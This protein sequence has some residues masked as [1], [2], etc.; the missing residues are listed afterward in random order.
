M[1]VPY[2][3]Y[4]SCLVVSAVAGTLLPQVAYAAPASSSNDDGKGIVDTVKGWFSDDD[5]EAD[6]PPVGGKLEIPSREKLPKGKKLPKAKRVKE[7]TERRTS[8]ARFF[9]LSDGRVEA[10]LSAVPVSYKAGKSWKPIDTAVR[11]TED[12]GFDFANTANTGRSW[13]GSDP[14]KL[15]RFESAGGGAISMGLT[16]AAA[17]TLKPQ[18]DGDTVTYKDA[19]SGADLQYKVGRGQVKENIVLAERPAGPVSFTFTLNTEGLT[20]KARK[21]GSVAFYGEAPGTPVMVIPAPYMTDAKKAPLSPTGGTYSTKVSQKLTRDGK[22]W[23][24]TVAPDAKWL[25]AKERQYPVVIDPTITVAPNAATSQDTM[26]LSDQPSV[27]FNSTWKMSAG[28]T[29]TGIA[30]SLI[31]FPLTEIP[32]GVKVDA[33][34]L[35]MY[36]DQAH[37]TNSNAVTI[38]AHRAT[39]A[40]DESTA[41]WSNTSALVG[42]LSAT[43]VMIDDG[44]V[45]T[46]AVGEWPGGTTTGGAATYDDFAYNK[47]ALTGETYSWQPQVAETDSYRVDVHYPAASDAATAAPYTVNYNGGTKNYTVNQTGTGGVWKTLD[48]AEYS[49]VKGNTGKVVLG[50][51]GSST[52]R[53]LADSVRLVNPAQIVKP[54]GKYNLWHDF[55]VTDTVQRWVS[56]VNPNY[57]FVL[58]AKDD[59]LAGTL[60]G[61]PRYE[62]GDGDYGGETSTIPRLT[63]TYGKVGTALNSPTVVHGTGPELSW[64]AY[65]NAGGAANDE[66]VE[67]QLH[68]ST[69]QVFTPSAA[70]L[71]APIA[72][73]A[74]TYTDTTAVPTPDSSSS[75]IGKSY[76]Y[77]L[78]VKT[79][80]GEL[81]GS[82]TRVVGI[83]K[84]G[85]TMKIIQ[86]GQT[87]T[88]L[89]SLQ[90]TTNQDAI[91]SLGVGQTWLSVGNNSPTYGKTRAVVKFPTSSIPTT[92]TV[93]ENKMYMWGAETTSTTNGAIYE[94]H[95]LTRDFTEN[96]ATWNNATLTTPWTTAGGDMS[97][98]V[99]DT[100][101]QITDEVG[102]HW[103]DATGLM[104]S[105]V[106]TPA[107]NKGVAV[108]LKD[109]TTTGPQER[110]LFLSSEASD[111]QLRPYMQ[112]IYVDSTTE[113][114][115]YAPT[116]PA[117]MTPNSQYTVEFTVTNTTATAWAAGERVLS[118]TWKIPDGTD[119]TTGGN[120]LS[121]AIPALLP[122]KSA[123][124][125][126]QVKTPINSDEGNKRLDYV[127]GWDVKKVADGTWLSA[128]TGAIPPL[129]QNVTV[130]DPTSNTLG[131]EKFYDYAGKNTGAGSTVM[132]NLASGNSVWSYNAINNPGRGL[133]TFARVAYNSLDTS[134]TVL[135][136]GWSAQISG[137]TRLG[138]PLEFHPKPS[139]TEIRLPDGD[140]TTHVFRWDATNSV[141]KAPAGVHY[142]LTM[143]AGLD[144]KPTKDPVPDAW[145]LTRPDGTRFLFGCDGYM[146][147]AVDN[148]GNTQ[149]YTYEERK[150]NN[151]PT[152]F[153][154]YITDP[155][156]R[157]S[158]TIDYYGKGDATY[159]YINDSG[160]KVSGTNLTNSKIYDHVKSI[161]DIST[162]KIS[163]YYTD[164]GLLGQIGDG[165]TSSQPKVFKF[166]YDA[167]Q[168]NKN[169]KLVKATD[170]RGNNTQ[171]AYYAPQTGDD[172]KYHWWTKTIT[173]RLAFTTGFAYKANTANTNFTDT[174]VTDAESHAT[175]HVTDDFF[176]PV[177][178]TDAKSQTTKMSWDADNNVTYM[179]AANGAKAAS[180]YDSKTG[181][182]LRQWDP[183]TTKSWSSF[184]QTDYCDPAKYPSG[185]TKFEYQTRLDGYS[186]DLFRKTSPLGNVWEFGYDAFGNQTSVTDP[187]GVASATAGDYQST[188]TYDAYGQPLTDT[189]ANGH[190][191]TYADYGP[192]GYPAT[193]K[194]A[195]NNPTT[196]VYDDRGN[197]KEVVN[198]KGAKVTQNYDYFGRPLDQKQP[199]DQ[200]AGVYITTPAPVY[201]ANNNTLKAFGPNGAETS[202]VYDAADQVTDSLAPK[203]E[204]TD[205]ERRTTTTYD[206]VGNVKTV[207]E[208]KGNLTPTVGDYTTTYTLDEVYRPVSVV[209]AKGDKVSSTYDSVGNLITVVDPKKNATPDSS[210]FTSKYDYDLDNRVV[211]TTDAA[212]K[213]TTVHY[214]LDGRTDKATDAE[215]NT[216]ETSFDRRGLTK[217][218]KVP[219][220]KDGSGVITYRATKFEYDEVGNKTKT[221][222]PRGVE[223]TSDA[224]DFT[225]ET[226]Y[227]ELNRVKETL[228]PFKQGDANYGSPDRTHYFYDTVGQL[229]KVSAPP[230]QG[231]TVRN[232]T[233]YEYYDNGWTKSAKDA[234]DITTA[235][236]YNTLGQ[237]TKNTLTSAGGSSQRTMTWDFYP[238]GNQKARSDDGVPVGKQVV[239]VDS[240]DIH[241]TATQGNWDASQALGQWGYDVRT[242]AKG[243][244][245]ESF[246]WQLNIPQDGTYEVFA[247]HG[248]VTGAATDAPF[249]IT[250][251]TGETTRTVNQS[252]GSGTWVSLGSYSFTESGSQKVTLTDAANGT[253]VADGIKL[254]R[255]NTGETDNEKKD[256][257]YKYDANGLL[258]EVKD[259]SPGAKADAYAMAYDELNQ[260]SK[261][262]EKLGSTVKNTTS[263]TYD[264]NGN[265]LETTHDVTWSKAEYDVR[266]M[267]NKITNADTPT[268]G[269]QQITTLSYTDRGQ[270]L[271]Q[272]KP[273]GNTVDYAYWL[274]GA[275]KSQVEKKSSGTVVASH[276]LEY[277]PNGNRSKDTAKLMNAD[278]T[279]AYLDTVSTFDYDPQDRISKVTKTGSGAGTEE[280]VYDGNSNI[281]EQKSGGITSTSTYDRNR[282]LKT[283][284]GGVASTYNYDPLGRLDTVSS[285]GSVQEKYSYDGFDRIAKH[286]A[287]TG[288]SAKTTSYVYDA[289]DRTASET[290]SGT[291]GKTTA[292]T[293]LGM[294]SKVL[295]EEVAGKA[296]KSY[297][298]SPWGQKLTQIKHKDTGPHEYSQF[299][300]HPKGDVEAITKEDGNTRATYGYTAY[301]S[302]DDAQFTGADKP[303]AANPDKEQYNDY[304]YNAHR[305]DDGSGTYDMGFRNYSP[306]LN[307]FLTRDMY[308]GALDDMS[309]ATDPYTG[310]RY[311]FAGGNP[312]SFVELDGHLFGMDISLSDVGHAALDVAGMVPVIGEAADVANGIWYAAEG[313]YADA[314]MSF[315]SAVPGVGNAVTAAKWAKK[316]AKAVDAVKSAAKSGGKKVAGKAK[317]G[318]KKAKQTVSKGTGKHRAPKGK[319]GGVC[320]KKNS[321]V[322]GT[323]VAMADGSTKNI[324]DLK[325]G[326]YVLASDPETGELQARQI[327]DTRNHSGVKHLIT[328]TVDPDGKDGDAKPATITATDE[329]PFWLPDFGKWVNA[330]DLEPGMWLQTSAGTWVQVTAVDESHRT[331]RVF[332]LTVDG[333]HTYY[334]QAG[335][336]PVLVHNCGNEEEAQHAYIAADVL[337]QARY[338]ATNESIPGV[339][340]AQG[341]YGT[342]AV[343]GVRN[344]TTGDISIRTA[345]NH[346]GDAPNS[347]PQWAQNAFVQ[348][349][350]HAETTILSSLADNEEVLFG[351]ASRNV[352]W[353]CH[354]S[355][356][357]DPGIV[358]GGPRFRGGPL[359]SPFRMFWRQ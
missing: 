104:Q 338:R 319:K 46:A 191:T 231:Q 234:F 2:R 332:N 203:D 206:K 348:G 139:P 184:N 306:G 188:T 103:W 57:G 198:A 48:A 92:A 297:Q 301:G 69:Q 119:V 86:A 264:V 308:G 162:R 170:P 347:W 214:D 64:P 24:L 274:N 3:R 102:R 336:T 291:N 121:T 229:S 230:S 25:A 324:E 215:G 254:V 90:P 77:Q 265:P 248:D 81:L 356:S 63:V 262:E 44:A 115:Y 149:T 5:E 302:D 351:A 61:G 87:D 147:S 126:A 193:I 307:R 273:N 310:N 67:Y 269:N 16:G 78:A 345:V 323:K 53:T 98:T 242:N 19:A 352:C 88:T 321:F 252:T 259:L 125:Q 359:A 238:S 118:Y 339:R 343:V 342:T 200:A 136:H 151:K 35:G 315:A 305:Y 41:T 284:A 328:L 218:V 107:N 217:E 251:S 96:Q 66:I 75:E 244:G 233:D 128:G 80:G 197:T 131:L 327:T 211:K 29:D 127:L 141:W 281:V 6:K 298:Y 247:R 177:Q 196:F 290:T 144:C 346:G 106:K 42:E 79:K 187:E 207:T 124:I 105:W 313:N 110:T 236:D 108:K 71:I 62:A 116:T 20:P 166:T 320:K 295:R 145:T 74:T 304:R 43:T 10:E 226:V 340:G 287:G 21:D 258:S 158:L 12:K 142:K 171:F 176:R 222:S 354:G 111:P 179:E 163:F 263:L 250:H 286:T 95:S 50:D 169:V 33:A 94:L 183:E 34:R 225:S 224:T 134:D 172:P 178:I 279:A 271:K 72:S 266:D 220:S 223:T 272:T 210:D 68:R 15:L 331:Q 97:A 11:A 237:Q 253:V 294:E 350:G 337:Q 154:K 73:T 7:L 40:W 205:S 135:G 37:T 278:N 246:T 289:F 316:G 47:N 28:K 173:D 70:T 257:T 52:T 330:E 341:Q 4:I 309:L 152:K 260:L 299:L 228:S 140:G 39:G 241:N 326:E 76:F 51:T 101:P 199:K 168:G 300:Y 160:A 227:D 56:G 268:A 14:D 195:L 204:A 349:E 109:E 146:T 277:D 208:P 353:G 84:A 60:T 267:I 282:L 322:P 157:Q 275:V 120:Q 239:V 255:A 49:F 55:P 194:D 181:Y 288:A 186:A 89:S 22:N 156:G 213:F 216:S 26:V 325:E 93:L 30:R 1:K 243:T 285:N 45:G 355:L 83:P 292:F 36:Y 318:A 99:A 344:T 112:V 167:T 189:D 114:T 129:K 13:F 27:N 17:N 358:I 161:T 58:Q 123:T 137:P 232:D 185:A 329:H 85:R 138:A 335:A 201:D 317:A 38:E 8:Q 221:I 130:E 122:G 165:E 153:L 100:V 293:Y 311:A 245:T 133:N 143:K 155:A 91:Q 175:D 357:S 23:K 113:D 9:E 270:P 276:D 174:K 314:A 312:I 82:P 296:T 18:A 190:A 65:V 209:N 180:C 219:Y 59:T 159:E 240:T 334:V 132:N 333:Q 148:D 54:A 303:D 32:A 283:A 256:F 202:S 261:V 212:G 192:H 280:Y 117:R 249:K 235:Y 164:K 31:K 150:S 182:P